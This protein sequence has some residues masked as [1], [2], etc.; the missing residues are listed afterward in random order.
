M[1]NK[2]RDIKKEKKGQLYLM[3]PFRDLCNDICASAI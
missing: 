1:Q 3:F 2:T